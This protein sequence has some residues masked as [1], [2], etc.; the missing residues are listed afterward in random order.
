MHTIMYNNKTALR[1]EWNYL[2]QNYVIPVGEKI[3]ANK[4]YV[5]KI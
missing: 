5:K 1:V 3:Q 2:M 4:K